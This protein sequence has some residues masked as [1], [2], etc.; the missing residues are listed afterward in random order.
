MTNALLIAKQTEKINQI[1]SL[2]SEY[3]H[4]VSLVSDLTATGQLPPDLHFDLIVATDSLEIK[5]DGDFLSCLRGQFPGT[6]F[7]YLG[8]EI[9]PET[10]MSL[11]SGGLIFLGSYD[12]FIHSAHQ[13]LGSI[14]D[15][16]KKL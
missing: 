4:K 1:E 2:L 12:H 11:R 3:F 5:P 10:E 7:V 9:A 6:K 15:S 13:I 8:N 14:A 16:V